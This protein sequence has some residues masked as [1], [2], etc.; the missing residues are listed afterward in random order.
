MLQEKIQDIVKVININV[1][2]HWSLKEKNRL[3]ICV[4]NR[5][6][7]EI[8]VRLQLLILGSAQGTGSGPGGD[9]G[10]AGLEAEFASESR[11][12]YVEEEVCTY[13]NG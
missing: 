9:S 3:T 1:V 7:P 5:N 8:P 10:G 4:L 12:Q 11:S 13:L 2:N 6:R